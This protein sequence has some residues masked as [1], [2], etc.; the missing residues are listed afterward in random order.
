MDNV[1][2]VKVFDAFKDL[3][4]VIYGFFFGHLP[5]IFEVAVEVM[6]TNL[7]YYVHIVVGLEDIMEFNNIS[8]TDFLHD[9]DF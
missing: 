5:F 9:V 8:V 3:F 1:V 6:V 7:C 4:Q 2:I